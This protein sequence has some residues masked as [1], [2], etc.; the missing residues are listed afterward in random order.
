MHRDVYTRM[1]PSV[2]NMSEENWE[3][4]KC[5]S[6]EDPLTK[7]YYFRKTK[8]YATIKKYEVYFYSLI[9]K[10][11]DSILLVEKQVAKQHA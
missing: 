7:L 4:Y 5:S 10:D 3:Q 8:C 6:V 9:W 11:F 2:S 1:W